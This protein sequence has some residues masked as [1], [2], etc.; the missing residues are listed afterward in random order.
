MKVIDDLE[1][2]RNEGG[3]KGGRD[4]L[5]TGD[6]GAKVDCEIKVEKSKK[7]RNRKDPDPDFRDGSVRK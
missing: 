3:R 5:L 2:A 6:D 7:G 4:K 1:G